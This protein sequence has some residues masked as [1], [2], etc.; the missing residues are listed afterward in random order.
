MNSKKNYKTWTEDEINTLKEVYPL[1]NIHQILEYLPTRTAVAIQRKVA[2]LKLRKLK[3]EL[4]HVRKTQKAYL[5]GFFDGDGCVT[6]RK[7]SKYPHKRRSYPVIIVTNTKKEIL[8]YFREI[9][10]GGACCVT[11]KEPIGGRV[12]GYQW[13]ASGERAYLILKAMYPYL[14]LKKPQAKVAMDFYKNLLKGSPE[15]MRKL[16]KDARAK[17]MKLNLNKG[18]KR[19]V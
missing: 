7:E 2:K 12:V 16:A 1:H 14:R 6:I 4:S 15:A 19:A 11:K 17:L 8:E 10:G 3:G 13:V 5:A 9:F 18:K